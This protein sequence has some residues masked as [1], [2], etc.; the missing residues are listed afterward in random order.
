MKKNWLLALILAA[1]LVSCFSMGMAAA[2]PIGVFLNGERIN[3]D[4]Q[5]V[6]ENERLLV[7]LRGIFETL[8]ADVQWIEDTSEVVITKGDD[9]I[10][11]SPGIKKASKNGSDFALDA[12]PRIVNGRILVP[13]R[14][15]AENLHAEVKWNPYTRAVSI[16]AS[17][18]IPGPGTVDPGGD[19]PVVGSL[20]NLRKLLE[21]TQAFDM[22]G[23][24]LN[25]LR[26]MEMT[27]DSMSMQKEA[28][29]SS[30]GSDEY[31]TTNIQVQGVDEADLVK[32]DGSYIYQVNNR[33]IVIT[34]VYPAS[35]MEISSIINFSDKG[36]TPGEIYLD[37]KHLIVMGTTYQEIPFKGSIIMDDSVDSSS[38]IMIYPPPHYQTSTVKAIIYDISDR[39]NITQLREIEIEG[40]Y[41]SSR[42]IGN[43]LYLVAN[44]HIDFYYIME[45]NE[46]NNT[47]S[48]RDTAVTDDFIQIGY[49]KIR[50]FPGFTRP[51]YMIIAG[52]NLER[53][54][55]KVE[56]HT[57]LGAGENIYASLENLYVAVTSD[58]N[59][60]RM[61]HA[62][63]TNIYKYK[64][65][66]GRITFAT[67]GEV[68]G[69][70]LNQFSMDEYDNHFRIATTSGNIWSTGEDTSKN[71]IYVLDS[72]L[73]VTGKIEDIAPGERIYSARFMG[74]K[75][76]I[77]TFRTVDPLFV[78][79]L[80][81]PT[82]PR[83]LGDLKIPGYSDY[84]HPYDENHLIGFGKDT[85]ELLHKDWMGNVIG[86]AVIDLGIK[87][88]LF[89]VSDVTN[90]KEKFTVMIGG[91]GTYSELLRNHRALLFNREK[92]LL[93]FPITVMEE[94]DPTRS[95]V[96]YGQFEFQGAYIYNLNPEEGFRLKGRITHLTEEDY[97][98]AG[99]YWYDSN[100][101]V[102][103]I[104]YIG[105][106][107]Y[108]LSPSQIKANN[109]GDLKEI[110]SL[111]IP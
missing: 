66:N 61:W 35:E 22:Y 111:L 101:N 68:P 30:P 72:N 3:F 23:R 60:R 59:G 17:G 25:M 12:A 21:D 57:Y 49:D 28:M 91:R 95:F 46:G 100:K 85:M 109:I 15:V 102:E 79:D 29:P 34:K 56:I 97:L 94:A 20:E 52:L 31:S 75:G 90:P 70:I 1:L 64:L 43:S 71:N 9:K 10:Q 53:P 13:V 58:D 55:E 87:M 6:L 47:P 4:V 51:N 78:I 107:L 84:L 106:T 89:D 69:T 65:N 24:D 105:D 39:K 41:V 44:K 27:D 54:D 40:H 62:L 108:T 14:F 45:G 2:Q 67:K 103:R 37:D 63:N 33:R 93:A 36:F 76:Y 81:D 50:Y 26:G 86:T 73:K 32:T 18:Y 98:K 8:G 88:A 83:I 96:E 82:N 11:L 5:P 110:N 38:R 80:K 92:G 104:L 19:L 74:E 42:K 7:P 48:F 77:V 16:L 99:R